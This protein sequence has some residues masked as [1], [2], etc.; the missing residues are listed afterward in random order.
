MTTLTWRNFERVYK[1]IDLPNTSTFW[2]I[3][4]VETAGIPVERVWHVVGKEKLYKEV[5]PGFGPRG[6]RTS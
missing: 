3:D 5:R 2:T 6:K 4:E 1:P